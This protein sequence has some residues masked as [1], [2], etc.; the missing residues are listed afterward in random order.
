MLGPEDR[1]DKR[2]SQAGIEMRDIGIN[3]LDPTSGERIQE[4]TL[5]VKNT[6]SKHTKL[7]VSHPRVRMV[8]AIYISHRW[9]YVFYVVMVLDLWLQQYMLDLPIKNTSNLHGENYFCPCYIYMND[10]QD[11]VA[12]EAFVRQVPTGYIKYA[13]NTSLFQRNKAEHY[14]CMSNDN[15]TAPVFNKT[16]MEKYGLDNILYTRQTPL[17]TAVVSVLLALV[18]LLD[19]LAKIYCTGRENFFG[20]E[21]KWNSISL[22]IVLVILLHALQLMFTGTIFNATLVLHPLVW[23]AKEPALRK[24]VQNCFYALY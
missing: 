4:A 16:S 21:H 17:W 11:Q 12:G 5:I 9:R 1:D 23:I 24:N 2:P 22:F 18:L 6:Y 19:R 8:H 3:D 15:N 10:D 7:H 20:K 14:V 13:T